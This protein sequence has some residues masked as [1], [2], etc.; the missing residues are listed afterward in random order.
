MCLHAREEHTFGSAALMQEEVA[1]LR[2]DCDR[3]QRSGHAL[4]H[5]IKRPLDTC[6]EGATLRWQCTY[7]P[8][9][10]YQ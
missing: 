5:V 1:L 6:S 9:N 3:L 8:R 7:L 2:E 10:Q 4:R